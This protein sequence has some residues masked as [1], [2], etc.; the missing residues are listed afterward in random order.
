ALC[1]EARKACRNRQVGLLLVSLTGDHPMSPASSA[2]RLES[3][4]GALKAIYYV[5]VGLAIT[6]AL[7]RAVVQDG[8]FAGGALLTPQRLPILMLLVAFL[9]TIMRF[10]HGSSIHLDV[11][12]G[13]RF[14]ALLDF[15]GFV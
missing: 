7:T 9:V 15:V 3:S 2:K 8:T 13:G 1:C 10:I 11:I 12:H 6:E 14:K 4:K 5:I